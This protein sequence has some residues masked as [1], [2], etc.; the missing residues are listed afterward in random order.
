MTAGSEIGN[1]E[2]TMDI[3]LKDRRL[4]N[5]REIS[6]PYQPSSLI[7]R[8]RCDR[9]NP[10]RSSCRICVGGWRTRVE[11]KTRHTLS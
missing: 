7:I 2:P 6:V 4:I 11:L 10:C 8:S 3:V 5:S 1:G 9:P